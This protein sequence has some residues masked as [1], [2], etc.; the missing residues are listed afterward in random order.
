MVG[1]AGLE[2]LLGESAIFLLNLGGGAC[3]GH[4]FSVTGCVVVRTEVGFPGTCFGA[5]DH[6]ELLYR[7]ISR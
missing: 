1:R 2:V 4:R 7:G 5:D 6:P 3:R